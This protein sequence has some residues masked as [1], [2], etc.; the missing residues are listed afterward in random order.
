M[1]FQEPSLSP[2][3]T[4]GNQIIENIVLHTRD[5]KEIARERTIQLLD[6]VG[7]PRPFRLVDEYPFRLSGGMLK[8]N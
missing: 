3:Y 8:S 6:Q 1:I 7:I 4:V 5:S 2:M